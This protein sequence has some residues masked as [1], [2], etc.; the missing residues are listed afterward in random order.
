[1]S[2]NIR[3]MKVA[4]DLNH[5]K[6]LIL[7]ACNGRAA[8]DCFGRHARSLRRHAQDA[9]AERACQHDLGRQGELGQGFR[10]AKIPRLCQDRLRVMEEARRYDRYR[11]L[12][13]DG[14]KRYH[15]R[16]H[17]PLY[18]Q[19]RQ[20]DDQRLQPHRQKDHLCQSA[21]R[22]LL[23][24]YRERRAAQM[25]GFQ[26]RGQIPRRYQDLQGLGEARNRQRYRL[27]AYRRQERQQ[28]FL[29]TAGGEQIRQGAQRVRRDKDQQ[30]PLRIL[31]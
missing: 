1:M 20:K 14:E 9:L 6:N 25:G 8:A 12:S 7:S 10:R 18:L 31:S 30:I 24:E 23:R 15:L 26:G 19:R 28:L 3:T 29:P 21:R 2:D 17:R 16:L 13:Q 5:Q 27:S 11:L 22:N 4:Y